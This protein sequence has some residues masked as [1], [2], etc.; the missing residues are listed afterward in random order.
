MYLVFNNENKC[1]VFA[2]T[3][4]NIEESENYTEHWDEI[5][6]ETETI[7]GIEPSKCEKNIIKIRFKSDDNLPLS[8]ILNIPMCVIIVKSV[9]QE[10]DKY[11]PQVF[12]KECFYEYEHKNQDDFYVVC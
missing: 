7:R 4:K 1:L 8:K 9:F 5:K 12:L 11:Y 10:N 6:S 2:L 3:D